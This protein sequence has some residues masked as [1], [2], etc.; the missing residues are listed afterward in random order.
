MENKKLEQLTLLKEELSKIED[1]AFNVYFYTV[2]SRGAHSGY[3]S[4]LY[5]TAYHLK[6]MGYNVH[7]LHQEQ[8]FVGVGSWMGEKYA[9]IPH[10]NIEKEQI[11]ISLSDVLFIPELFSNVMK[12]TEKAPCKRVIIMQNMDLMTQI[13]PAGQSWSDF[14][15]K[16]CVT[17]TS[18][19]EEK[20]KGMF[21][22][23]KTHVVE[24]LV[25]ENIFNHTDEPK[26]LIVNIVAKNQS[27][28]NK[29][30]KPFFW[31]YPMYRWVAFRELRGLKREDFAE[32][33]KESAITVWV[34]TDTYFG[35]SAVEALKCGNIVIGK[36]P[37]TPPS[38]MV[39]GDEFVNNGVWYY[40][41][42]DV[43]TLI[44]GAIESF[45][46][47]NI[48]PDVYNEIDKMNVAYT[49][50]SFKESLKRVYVDGI[51]ET[52]K[53]N[54]KLLLSSLESVNK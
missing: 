23:L 49:T 34:D 52:H 7:M 48:H 24:P 25:D 18:S 30:V 47:D 44:A 2:D 35:Y 19:L 5:E 16:E 1:K 45:I 28:V 38:W 26:K 51:F 37:E 4:Y 10:H 54:I 40:N 20:L 27:D 31:K 43:H 3:L 11:N 15:I 17:S 6:E 21:P 9:E 29:I 41:N 14:G 32:A 12:H 50:T 46:K 53:N 13:I 33:L 39:N 8:D 36:V 42:D 22:S